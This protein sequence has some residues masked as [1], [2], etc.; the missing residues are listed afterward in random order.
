MCT[1]QAAGELLIWIKEMINKEKLQVNI[2]P[3]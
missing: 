3:E 1:L 2:K